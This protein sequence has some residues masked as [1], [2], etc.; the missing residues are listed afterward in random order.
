MQQLTKTCTAHVSQ[1]NRQNLT[2]CKC[3]KH[4]VEYV[5]ILNW[6]SSRMLQ[7]TAVYLSH[8]LYSQSLSPNQPTFIRLS[9]LYNMNPIPAQAQFALRE[10]FLLLRHVSPSHRQSTWCDD[11]P[12]VLLKWAGVHTSASFGRGVRDVSINRVNTIIWDYTGAGKLFHSVVQHCGKLVQHRDL[13]I[14]S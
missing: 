3:I 7:Q 13:E 4:K 2:L 8:G 12:P 10:P 11:A 14:S 5:V 1:R 9:V 6:C